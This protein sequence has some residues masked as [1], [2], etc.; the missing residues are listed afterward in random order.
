MPLSQSKSLKITATAIATTC[1]AFGI[2]AILRPD[3][4]LTFFE[5][6]APTSPTE[7]RVVD[8]LLAVYGIRDI[9]M[10]LAVYATAFLGSRKAL[11]WILI[12]IGGV[13]LGDGAIC[14][15]H[16]HGQWGHWGYAP[17]AALVG[18]LMTG[19]LDAT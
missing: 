13:A 16:G 14:W 10:G 19:V 17:V 15:A 18:A 5:W 7:K 9:F 6:E 3:H 2:N 11:G 12:A 4:A 1:I 8:D